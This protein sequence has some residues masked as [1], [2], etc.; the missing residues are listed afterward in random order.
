VHR[1]FTNNGSHTIAK[2]IDDFSNLVVGKASNVD[3]REEVI[4]LN[5]V[6]F[7]HDFV[8]HFLKSFTIYV[9]I[10]GLICPFTEA[11]RVQKSGRANSQTATRVGLPERSGRSPDRSCANLPLNC[12]VSR[13]YNT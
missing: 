12:T 1:L 11:A 4:V 9:F 2:P 8:D 5:Y 10:V 6:V 3:L 13:P 7:S